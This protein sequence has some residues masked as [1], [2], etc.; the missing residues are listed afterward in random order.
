[1]VV[2]IQYHQDVETDINESV[3]VQKRDDRIR[4]AED[5]SSSVKCLDAQRFRRES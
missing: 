3:V 1:M 5:D 2:W 4:V